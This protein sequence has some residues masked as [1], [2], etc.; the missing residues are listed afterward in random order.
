MKTKLT[1]VTTLVVG[2]IVVA[3]LAIGDVTRLDSIDLAQS[4]IATT[5]TINPTGQVQ[6]QEYKLDNPSRLVIDLVGVKNA[7]QDNSLKADGAMV[8]AIRA[9]Q[10]QNE[11][12]AVTRVVFELAAGAHYK[13]TR[14][15]KSIDV[16]FSMAPAV[17]GA[18]MGGENPAVANTPA[19]AAS[20]EPAPA[21]T[22]VV[23][24]SQ[25]EPQVAAVSKPM[26]P[27]EKPAMKDTPVRKDVPVAKDEPVAAWPDAR[28][29]K[30]V[31]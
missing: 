3:A 31:V 1:I 8:T 28:D 17:M 29:R 22:P 27:A 15:D 7:I 30:S 13:V 10:F 14:R 25:S 12:D 19:P 18:S 9:S 11:P 24:L 16:S 4:P 2:L 21:E 6:Y 23:D 5:Y 20:K 26:A